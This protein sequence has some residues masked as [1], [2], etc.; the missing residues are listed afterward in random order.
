MGVFG[1]DATEVVVGGASTWEGSCIDESISVNV[2]MGTLWGISSGDGG[3]GS[4]SEFWGQSV[5]RIASESEKSFS[6]ECSEEC[7]C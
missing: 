4:E 6:E 1:W 3:L 5:V 7:M 2:L